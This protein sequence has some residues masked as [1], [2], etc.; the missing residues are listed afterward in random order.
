M[1]CRLHGG[2]R[3]WNGG[4]DDDGYRT[5]YIT[6]AVQADKE[7]GPAN[8]MQTPG[9]PL[10]GALWQFKADVDVWAFCYL[11]MEVEHLSAVEGDPSEWWQVKQ[12]FSTKPMNRCSDTKVED[13]LLEPAKVSGGFAKYTKEATHDRHGRAILTSSWE[14]YKGA[15][16]EFDAGRPDVKISQNV[17]HLEL[18]VFSAMRDTV[19]DAPMW[20]LPARCVKLSNVTWERNV[21][22]TCN[23]YYTRNFEFDVDPKTFD[24]ILPDEGTRV[25]SGHWDIR[26]K[27]S[28]GV[29]YGVKV[30]IRAAAAGGALTY[31]ELAEDP[32]DAS[33]KMHGN[34]FLPST[35]DMELRLQG[36]GGSGGI[37]YATS[38][39]NGQIVSVRIQNSG[40]TG[41]PFGL[42]SGYSTS[43]PLNPL[44]WPYS[45][46]RF[47]PGIPAVQKSNVATLVTTTVSG[48]SGVPSPL[49][50]ITLFSGGSGY[51]ANSTI[52]LAIHGGEGGVCTAITNASGTVTS[53]TLTNPGANYIPDNRAETS[54][55]QNTWV[56]DPINGL[57]PDRFNPQHFVA[58]TD[59]KGNKTKVA[60]DGQ[61]RPALSPMFNDNT[62][63]LS[64][65]PAFQKI[66]YYPESNFL[67]FGIPLEL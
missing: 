32:T 26:E 57:E 24:R 53:V 58:Y 25:L 13:P 48:T 18:D 1:T 66:E 29:G 65:D 61:G 63:R 23:F 8:V 45:A 30:W 37:I 4:I 20:G 33:K 2:H 14:R 9:L 34:G 60:L 40:D 10:P 42:G 67:L 46:S 36:G 38:D 51:P 7:D 12:K 47:S 39:A 31:V 27:T 6:W 62:F 15:D 50:T 21:R 64:G 28:V 56:L 43:S 52:R 5:Y 19:N 54:F 44:V 17:P 3:V 11:W 16:V 49:A 41:Y 59:A 35:S 55:S 22:G